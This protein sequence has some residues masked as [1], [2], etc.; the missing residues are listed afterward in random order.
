MSLT[1]IGKEATIEALIYGCLI[2]I[3]FLIMYLF[4]APFLPHTYAF[5]GD[6]LIGI[7]TAAFIIIF[8]LVTEQNWILKFKKAIRRRPKSNEKVSHTVYEFIDKKVIVKAIED[9]FQELESN[10]TFWF[11]EEEGKI[12]YLNWKARLLGEPEPLPYM[13][14]DEAKP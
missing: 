11:E 2:L 4:L 1:K 6:A 10:S 13:N 3:S 8:Y 5:D 7:F 12:F 14:V 9:A